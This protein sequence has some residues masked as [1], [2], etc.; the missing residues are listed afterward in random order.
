MPFLEDSH[1]NSIRIVIVSEVLQME[2]KGI[3]IAYS[4]N[5]R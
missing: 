3:S 4:K 5:G 1:N 2:V